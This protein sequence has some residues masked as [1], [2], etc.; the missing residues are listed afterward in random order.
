MKKIFLYILLILS[1][2]ILI[3]CTATENSSENKSYSD[4]IKITEF[5]YNSETEKIITADNIREFNTDSDIIDIFKSDT[6]Y[7]KSTMQ[8]EN[9]VVIQENVIFQSAK[10]YIAT[11]DDKF[12]SPT[13]DVSTAFGYDGNIVTILK[14]LGEYNDWHLYSFDAGL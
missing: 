6:Y 2:T 8:N 14:Y 4:I 9:T 13:L 12:N 10:G 7:Y 11:K 5:T 3:G 1:T